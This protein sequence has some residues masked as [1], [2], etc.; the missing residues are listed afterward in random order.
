M[1]IV[2]P[3]EMPQEAGHIPH[4]G[5][6]P[7]ESRNVAKPCQRLGLMPR[8]WYSASSRRRNR[9]SASTDCRGL[10]NSATKPTRSAS[11]R[12]MIRTKTITL[13]SCHSSVQ[14][15]PRGQSIRDRI[16]AEHRPR[17]SGAAL[18]APHSRFERLTIESPW[19]CGGGILTIR[20][21]GDNTDDR[22]HHHRRPA[23]TG[24]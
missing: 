20:H 16:F 13:R 17:K 4:Q 7:F 18:A 5:D 15:V 3:G 9:F 21:R 24:A 11:N 22:H 19:L 1:P 12:R 6:L 8:S 14:V 2:R 23:R 10:T